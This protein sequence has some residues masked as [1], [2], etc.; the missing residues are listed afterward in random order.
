[1]TCHVVLPSP[2]VSVSEMSR[3]SVRELSNCIKTL[4]RDNEGKL[5]DTLSSSEYIIQVKTKF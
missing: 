1:M 2:D 4:I 5:A 3:Q